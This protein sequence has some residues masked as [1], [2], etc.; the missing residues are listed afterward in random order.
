MKKLFLLILVIGVTGIL[1][2]S[3]LYAQGKAPF[4]NQKS[5]QAGSWQLVGASGFSTGT[6]S[7]VSLAFHPSGQPWVAFED[8]GPPAS[9]R[10]MKFD[11][12]AWSDAGLISNSISGEWL[13]L[14]FDASGTPMV[15]FRQ[16][17]VMIGLASV[18]HYDG[19]NWAFKGNSKFS[20]GDVYHTSMAVS[21]AGAPY[22]VYQDAAH[23]SN[24][25]VMKYDGSSWVNVGSPGFTNAF[26]RNPVIAFSP[27]GI[28]YIAYG[29]VS[30]GALG[31]ATVMKFNGSNWEF[32][33][34]EGFSAGIMDSISLAFSP[35]GEP[36]VA[37]SDGAN[38]WKATVMRFDG[39]S[40]V[41]AGNPG[42]SDGP[43]GWTSI[44]F[45]QGGKAVVAFQDGGNGYKASVMI[46]DGSTWSYLGT[47][48]FS[49]GIS[50]CT[51]L[52]FSL[53]GQ[54]YVA[55]TDQGYT[56]KVTVMMYDGPLGVGEIQKPK[57]SVYPD[58]VQKL[59]TLE[60]GVPG[61]TIYGAEILNILGSPVMSGKFAGSSM[62]MN[63]ESLP[64]GIYFVKITGTGGTYTSRFIKR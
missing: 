31:E 52:R 60:T 30:S 16:P 15:G 42:F 59:L 20:A 8:W 39:T 41:N 21:P 50:A 4:S 14:D 55:F 64:D 18:I 61:S 63:V 24:G 47:P 22:I 33:G 2:N 10:V 51:R 44:A 36:W 13:S 9:F 37:Y 35:S 34:I 26:T 56:G 3:S 6:T 28:P 5:I 43:A 40:W 45:S 57:L 46:F 25:T 48:G 54:P 62:Q 19:N 38:S 32:V 1:F 49:A 17:D 12:T 7:D 23:N 53:T 11:G 58:P 27:A 29:G